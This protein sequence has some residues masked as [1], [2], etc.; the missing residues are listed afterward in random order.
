MVSTGIVLLFDLGTWSPGGAKMLW[1][2]RTSSI[3]IKLVSGTFK[4]ILS[5]EPRSTSIIINYH[6]IIFT[7]R[8]WQSHAPGSDDELKMKSISAMTE[9]RLDLSKGEGTCLT[10]FALYFMIKSAKRC[11][12]HFKMAL[13]CLSSALTYWQQATS[14][15]WKKY[16]KPYKWA[17]SPNEKFI[18]L[19]LA[20]MNLH[21]H[22]WNGKKNSF[23]YL[24]SISRSNKKAQ[25][26]TRV[27]RK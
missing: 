5:F 25:Y 3:Y 4:E 14:A 18:E 13:W 22:Y 27:Y 21:F 20:L 26:A 12:P 15:P 9:N 1:I 8:P 19:F 16:N 24:F 10:A 7:S 23:I 11:Q 6:F 2:T 17:L